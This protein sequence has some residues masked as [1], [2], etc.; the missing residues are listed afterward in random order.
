MILLMVIIYRYFKDETVYMLKEYNQ[1][2]RLLGTNEYVI[3]NG[4]TIMH[5]KFVNYNDKGIKISEGQFFE[6]EPHGE[7][8]YYTE[9]GK[10]EVVQYRKNS[11]I[12]LESTFYNSKGYIEKYVVYDDIGHSSFIIK[13][14]EKGVIRYDG[15][16]QIE[17]YQYK[18]TNKAKFNIKKEQNLKVGDT[19]KYSYIVANI[20]NTIR[21]FQ[22]EN[23]KVPGSEVVRILK[24]VPPAQ[25]DVKE[26]LMKKGKNTIRSI[27]KYEFKDKITPVFTDTISFDINV[28]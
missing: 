21:S 25:I 17:V 3:R 14:D 28:N 18:F 4:D 24:N 11:T 27:V 22:I 10:K 23:L 26:V 5:G 20:P 13:Y 6:D 7:C 2:G 19:L 16:P 15:Y 1:Q 12:T 9:D 8:I